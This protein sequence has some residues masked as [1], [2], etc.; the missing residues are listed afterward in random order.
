MD[1]E[2]FQEQSLEEA[3]KEYQEKVKELEALK[4]RKARGES[5]DAEISAL[6]EHLEYLG[7]WIVDR[8]DRNKK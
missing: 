2:N 3:N 4:E 7:D 1:D 8:E 6:T 5:V